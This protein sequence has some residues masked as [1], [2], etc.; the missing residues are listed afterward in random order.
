VRSACRAERIACVRFKT[1]LCERSENETNRR[2]HHAELN[3]I[4]RVQILAFDARAIGCNM[5]LARH[6]A[7]SRN[8]SPAVD[9]LGRLII[10]NRIRHSHHP[11]LTMNS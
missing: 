11:V 7:A 2:P 5:K 10:Q 4:Y 1:W 6:L 9:I 8:T 3:G